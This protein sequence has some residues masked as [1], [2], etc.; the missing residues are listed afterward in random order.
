MKRFYTSI[1]FFSI[2]LFPLSGEVAFDHPTFLD[3]TST[4]QNEPRLL[5]N[6]RPLAKINGKVISL[7]DVIK[8]MDLFLFDYSPE[9]TPTVVERYQF[10]SSRWESTLEDMIADELV[11][12]DAEQKEMAFFSP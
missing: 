3:S 12:I 6:N 5:I 10:Y 11:L 7:F 1:F 2:F 8:K 9:Y 4:L